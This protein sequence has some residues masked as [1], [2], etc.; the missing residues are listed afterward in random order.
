MTAK[1]YT[2]NISSQTFIKILLFFV[3]IAFLYMVREAIAL[4][5]IAL[6]LASAL[7][8][9][10]DWLRKFKIPRG[11]GIIVIYLLLLSIISAVIIM[12]IPPI[13]AEIKLI[14]SD[15]PVYYERVVDGF[16]YFTTNRTDMEVA[17]QLQNSLNTITGNLSRAASGV[18]DTLMGIF[19]GIF[20]FF[21]VL[22]ITF[23]FTVEEEGLKRFIMSVTP[24]QY[25]PYLMQLV[26]RIQRKLGYWLRGQLILSVIIF[27]L[28]FVGLTVLGVEYALL[29]ALIAGIFEVIP[30]MGPIIAAVPAVFLAFMQSPLKGLLVLI[31]YIIIQ[32]LENHIIV[33]KVMSKSVGINPLVVIIV[34]LVGGKLGGVMGM[35]LAVPVAT[36]ISVFMDDFVDKRLG[37]KEGSE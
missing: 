12:I 28:T 24:A 20:S 37:E 10:V 2:V 5:F 26:S 17:E 8:P 22:V 32:Q 31:L 13:T 27:I 18:F 23:Y 21:L 36:A 7:D 34:L 25:Q 15:F 3:V 4:I 19:G 33:P 6:I 9:F 30:Y 35:V 11:V 29:L 16:N 1:N 14:A